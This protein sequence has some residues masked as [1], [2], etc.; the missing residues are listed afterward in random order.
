M[1]LSFVIDFIER[2][3]G[4]VCAGSRPAAPRPYPCSTSH[5][6][7]LG[8]QG[9][10][11]SLRLP[12]AQAEPTSGTPYPGNRLRI[13]QA[14]SSSVNPRRWCSSNSRKPPAL[15][16][17]CHS[18]CNSCAARTDKRAPGAPGDCPEVPRGRTLRTPRM[19]AVSAGL[20]WVDVG[21]DASPADRIGNR[22][23]YEGGERPLRCLPEVRPG[24]TSLAVS[25]ARRA[26]S[27]I[28]RR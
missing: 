25:C 19:P 13:S 23:S 17:S 26:G 15:T 16:D 21:E 22:T 8:E 12:R 11:Q 10:C 27:S 9:R 14:S 24:G 7:Q 2:S 1:W 20:R 6:G 28:P 18:Y 5:P 4:H 3:P